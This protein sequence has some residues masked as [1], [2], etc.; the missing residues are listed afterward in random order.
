[1]LCRVSIRN[2]VLARPKDVNTRVE[3]SPK[4][5][6]IRLWRRSKFAGE[7]RIVGIIGRTNDESLCIAP[8]ANIGDEFNL[9]GRQLIDIAAHIVEQDAQHVR[10]DFI[11]LQHL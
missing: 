11:K 3:H 6:E 9:K 5:S 4:I 1:M 8:T 10:T 7:P 2:D